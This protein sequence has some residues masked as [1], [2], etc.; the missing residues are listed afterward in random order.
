VIAKVETILDQLRHL[1][2]EIKSPAAD[3]S[4]AAKRVQ[5]RAIG[6]SIQQLEGK[7][8]PVPN[9]LRSLKTTLVSEISSFEGAERARIALTKGL[10]EVLSSLNPP[11]NGGVRAPR[12]PVSYEDMSNT[13]PRSVRLWGSSVQPVSSWREVLKVVCDKV[14][15]RHVDRVSDLEALGGRKRKYF[16]R[17]PGAFRSALKLSSGLYV[18][19]HLSANAIFTFLRRVMAACGESP[20]D[21]EIEVK[22]RS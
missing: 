1:A 19:S 10:S 8:V 7:S 16:G 3:G 11:C 22:S 14:L 12:V 20:D 6:Q 5:L 2:E 21:L 15:E 17:S 18:E 9:E 13:Q 4:L